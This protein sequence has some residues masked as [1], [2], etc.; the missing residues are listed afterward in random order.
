MIPIHGVVR[1]ILI[2][3][4]FLLGIPRLAADDLKNPLIDWVKKVAPDDK[5]GDRIEKNQEP[6]AYG[7]GL[8]GFIL[9]FGI[10]WYLVRLLAYLIVLA[11]FVGGVILICEAIYNQRITTW[12]QLAGIVLVIGSLAGTIAVTANIYLIKGGMGG[13]GKE[14]KS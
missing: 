1:L 10:A 5:G 6:W 2:L 14:Q 4:I 7:A 13:T 12:Q 9:V 11:S 3:L 8:L